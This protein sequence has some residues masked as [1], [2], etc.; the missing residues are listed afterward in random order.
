MLRDKQRKIIERNR[1]R[2]RLQRTRKLLRKM[3]QLTRCVSISKALLKL[4][5][6]DVSI[7]YRNMKPLSLPLSL[8]GVGIYGV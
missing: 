4:K 5:N 7:K 2:K 1:Q 3:A 8:Q 6:I